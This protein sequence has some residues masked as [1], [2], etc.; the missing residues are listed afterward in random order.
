MVCSSKS[1]NAQTKN[2][3]DTAHSIPPLE[4][5]PARAAISESV[6]M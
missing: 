1:E 5:A 2:I 4:S 3:M 6:L